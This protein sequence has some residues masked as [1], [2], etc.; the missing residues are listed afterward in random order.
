MKHFG[1]VSSLA[2]NTRNKYANFPCLDMGTRPSSC[3]SIFQTLD[4]RISDN[5]QANP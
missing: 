1:H 4:Y 2:G 3:F 5:V